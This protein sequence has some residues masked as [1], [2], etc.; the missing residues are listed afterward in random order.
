M[1]QFYTAEMHRYSD[2]YGQP[3]SGNNTVDWTISCIL[4]AGKICENSQN[5]Y[6]KSKLHSNQAYTI[7]SI[8][9]TT[10]TTSKHN[11]YI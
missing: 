7:M 11:C 6:L 9:C 10:F 4:Y 5:S 8:N 2:R 3:D 1:N